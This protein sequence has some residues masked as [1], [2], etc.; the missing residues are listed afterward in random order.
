MQVVANSKFFNTNYRNS[1]FDTRFKNNHLVY[2]LPLIKRCC[3]EN[4]K[5]CFN[6]LNRCVSN[7]LEIDKKHKA[8]I[9][10]TQA[11]MLIHLSSQ[12]AD[13]DHDLLWQIS[14]LHTKERPKTSLILREITVL[15][16]H[17]IHM[18][19]HQRQFKMLDS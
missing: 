7:Y 3:I 1:N 2:F 5:K 12:N 19:L 17:A 11:S 4:Y 13:L 10:P 14:E 8:G 18:P 16:L 15:P 6:K 9:Y